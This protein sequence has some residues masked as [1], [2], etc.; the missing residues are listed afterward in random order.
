MPSPRSPDARRPPLVHRPPPPLRL[1][2]RDARPRQ[3]TPYSGLA[4]RLPADDGRLAAPLSPNPWPALALRR[5][6]PPP[7]RRRAGGRAALPQPTG[8]SGLPGVVIAASHLRYADEGLPRLSPSTR[9]RP[10]LSGL[11]RCLS[12]NLQPALALR[13]RVVHLLQPAA[14]SGLPG[15]VAAAVPAQTPPQTVETAKQIFAVVCTGEPNSAL[16][17]FPCLQFP[18]CPV[19]PPHQ[20]QGWE[21]GI[22]HRWPRLRRITSAPN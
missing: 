14:G 10:S 18:R 3:A 15:V 9:G 16:F 1:H 21:S 2:H 8:G 4:S 17:S 22:E 19:L 20:R 12:P 5:R 11:A 7:R 13:P 6:E